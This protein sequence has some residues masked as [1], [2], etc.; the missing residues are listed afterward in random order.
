[1]SKHLR[2]ID[3]LIQIHNNMAKRRGLRPIPLGTRFTF[4]AIADQIELVNKKPI[5]KRQQPKP[6]WR[7]K[8]W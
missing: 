5:R 1:M 3:D 8:W 7:W 4:D 6:K 2:K